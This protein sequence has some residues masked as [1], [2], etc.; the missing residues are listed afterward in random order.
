MNIINTYRKTE[1]KKHKLDNNYIGNHIQKYIWDV[2]VDEYVMIIIDTLN[3]INTYW[4]TENVHT[5]TTTTTPRL[6]NDANVSPIN[7]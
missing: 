1:N 2:K 6:I 3:I 4:K 7:K 5:I